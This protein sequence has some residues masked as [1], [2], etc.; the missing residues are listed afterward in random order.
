MSD[1]IKNE[2]LRS[3]HKNV[4]GTARK[5]TAAR[6]RLREPCDTCAGCLVRP[7][8]G[9]HYVPLAVPFRSSSSN[10]TFVP[11]PEGV[12]EHLR[13]VNVTFEYD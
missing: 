13:E 9:R 6:A 11:E 8:E 4:P 5:G 3:V 12:R 1:V 10:M 7:R 2:K